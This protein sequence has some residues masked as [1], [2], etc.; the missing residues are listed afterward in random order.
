MLIV[1]RLLVV[2]AGVSCLVLGL[3]A[4]SSL[5]RVQAG[6]LVRLGTFKVPSNIRSGGQANAGFEYGGTAL[7]FNPAQNSLFMVGH[8][9]DQLSGEISIPQIGG[10]A[11][12]LQ[13]LR[14]ATEGRMSQINPGDSNSKMIGGQLAWGNKLIVSA[15]SYYDGQGSQVLSHFTRPLSLST[16]G[17]LAGPLRVGPLGAG[18]YSGYMGLIPAEWQAKLGGPALT[19]NADLG[20]ISRTSYG[21]AVFAFDPSNLSGTGAQPLV[22]YPEAHQSLGSWA[23]A[24]QLYGGADTVKGIV[25]PSGTSTVLFFGKH[26]ATFCYGVGTSNQA[27]DGKPSGNGVD[28]YCYDP[29]DGGKGVHGYPY[30]PYVWAYDANDLAAVHSGSKQPWDLR[31][32]AVWSLPGMGAQVGGAAYDPA[33]KR[34]YVTEMFGDSDRPIVHVFEVSIGT[35][36]TATAPRAPVNVRIIG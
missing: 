9:W 10:T 36:P 12:L 33:T 23:G 32:Y 17:Q 1:K 31:P 4:Q 6:D 2:L 25:F 15:Y 18:F 3:Q 8:L 16:T 5:P 21:P 35:T 20:V 14:D 30:S 22:Y 34:I 19:G 24:N 27:L 13:P 26:G 7:A 28:P 29:D 11:T